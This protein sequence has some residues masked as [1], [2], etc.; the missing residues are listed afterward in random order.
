MSMT[1]YEMAE[2]AKQEGKYMLA[3]RLY[4]ISYMYWENEDFPPYDMR[5][6][7]LYGNYEDCCKKL[8]NKE[9]KI[10]QIEEREFTDE[11]VVYGSYFNWDWKDCV[12]NQ[13]QI[14][15]NENPEMKETIDILLKFV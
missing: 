3:A 11:S 13:L 12:K 10:L 2:R 7:N 8:D 6:L 9:Q 15:M 1:F 14:I 5:G 4:R